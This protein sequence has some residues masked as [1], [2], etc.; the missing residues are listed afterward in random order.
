MSFLSRVQNTITYAFMLALRDLWTMPIWEG[1]VDEYFPK[2]ARP[3]RPS[4][5]E[6]EKETGLALQFGNP[7]IADGMRPVSPNYVMIGMM[8]C[9]KGNP[10]PKWIKNFVEGR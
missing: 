10:L 3:N 7:L 8:N 9:R 2:D 1:M 5:L 4:L 6:L